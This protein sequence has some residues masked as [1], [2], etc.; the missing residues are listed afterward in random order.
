MLRKLVYPDYYTNARH[1]F[2]H[3]TDP[4]T[5]FETHM[6]HCVDILMQSL[7][8]NGNL[9]LITMHWVQEE[10]IPFPDMSVNRQCMADFADL[11]QWRI[12]NTVDLDKYIAMG[13]CA[14]FRACYRL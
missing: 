5:M 4:K 6:A 10:S 7:Q 12:D 2:M 11:T 1:Q 8:C 9:N 3:S 13:K 14:F